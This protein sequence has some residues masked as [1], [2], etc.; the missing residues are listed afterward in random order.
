MIK[1]L[2]QIF[3]KLVQQLLSDTKILAT[4]FVQAMMQ[5]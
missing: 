2:Q 4:S 3:L 5:S 1:K